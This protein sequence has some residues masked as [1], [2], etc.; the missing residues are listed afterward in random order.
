MMK[1]NRKL[2]SITQKEQ[3][4]EWILNMTIDKLRSELR[5][6][7]EMVE[8]LRSERDILIKTLGCVQSK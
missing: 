7:I 2:N 4:E 6:R 3:Q 5:T 8:Q 1:F